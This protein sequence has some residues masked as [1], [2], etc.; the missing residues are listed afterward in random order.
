ML[1]IRLDPDAGKRRARLRGG[2]AWQDR[3]AAV[4]LR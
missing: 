2:G 1:L 3:L 4:S